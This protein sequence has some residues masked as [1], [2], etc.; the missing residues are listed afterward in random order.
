MPWFLLS[1]F[2]FLQTYSG[3]VNGGTLQMRFEV[4]GLRGRFEE[5]CAEIG[6]AR[7]VRS[8]KVA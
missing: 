2:A 1:V 8:L 4:Q 6:A 3:S 7:C 5:M